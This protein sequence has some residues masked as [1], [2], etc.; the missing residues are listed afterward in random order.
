MITYDYEYNVSDEDILK[1]IEFLD[2]AP[3]PTEKRKLW[4]EEGI[5]ENERTSTNKRV[6]QSPEE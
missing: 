4:T 3:V 1:V 6:K 5:I 2:N